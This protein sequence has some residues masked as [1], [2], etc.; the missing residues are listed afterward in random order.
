MTSKVQGVVYKVFPKTWP[1]KR[2]G[3]KPNTTYSIKLEND[4]FYYRTPR[5]S[6]KPGSDGMSFAGI[7][8]P[9]NTVEFEVDPINDNSA[10]IVGDVKKV[11]AQTATVA[12]LPGTQPSASAS[13]SSGGTREASIHYQSSRKDALAFLDIAVRAN[14]VKLPAK[15]SAKLEALEALADFYTSA[16]FSDVATFGA[17]ARANGTADQDT[18]SDKPAADDAE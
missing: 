14:A 16:Y 17:V 11:E 1:S 2:P 6:E 10:Q 12:S 3:G 5:V 9:G 18:A 7:A 13:A 15:E 8:E 4:P